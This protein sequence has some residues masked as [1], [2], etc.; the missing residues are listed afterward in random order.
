MSLERIYLLDEGGGEGAGAGARVCAREW[1][2][3]NFRNDERALAS[4]GKNTAAD[5][6]GGDFLKN[7]KNFKRRGQSRARR[8]RHNNNIVMRAYIRGLFRR[9]Y[10]RAHKLMQTQ[11]ARMRVMHYAHAGATRRVPCV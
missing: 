11:R 9:A 6:L 5:P 2:L 1:K 7:Y 10:V 8:H 4:Y 3:A